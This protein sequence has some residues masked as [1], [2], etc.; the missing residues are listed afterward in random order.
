MNVQ[1]LELSGAW[2]ATALPLNEIGVRDG[3]YYAR[4]NLF[5]ESSPTEIALPG[6]GNLD[7][8]LCSLR[9]VKAGARWSNRFAA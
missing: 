3:V 8:A 1:E 4:V 9:I 2:E 5:G 6:A 7:Q